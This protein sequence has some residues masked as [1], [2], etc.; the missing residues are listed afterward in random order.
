MKSATDAD[1][2]TADSPLL[3]SLHKGRGIGGCGIHWS[4]AWSAG[5]LRLTS[6]QSMPACH[7]ID[8][9]RDWITL[10]RSREK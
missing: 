2:L 9:E 10:W 4:W 3:N 7:V 6:Y 1:G 8:E 5:H